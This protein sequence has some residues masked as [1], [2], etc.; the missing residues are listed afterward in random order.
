MK[1]STLVRLLVVVG[2]GIPLVVEGVTFVGLFNDGLSG[3]SSATQAPVPEEV[4]IGEDLLAETTASETLE[5]TYV[6][7]GPDR[8]TMV[9]TV[10]VENSGESPYRLRLGDATLSSGK[11]VEG[12]AATDRL[13]PGESTT[14]TARWSLPPGATP[15]KIAVVAVT[16]GER[17]EETVALAK[18]PVRRS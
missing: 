18:V 3:G 5:S 4:G 12:G 7:A 11:T 13:A 16:D 2:F 17:V 1:R 9:V 15:R 6:V 14:I 8:W 10:A